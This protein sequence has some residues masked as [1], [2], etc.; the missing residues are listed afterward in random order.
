MS[1][2]EKI[3]KGDFSD[4][5]RD[6]K[7]S[8]YIHPSALARVFATL[9]YA[10]ALQAFQALPDQ[11]QVTTFSYL[12][13]LLQCK[14]IK[15][16]PPE[17]SAFI[18]NELNSDDRMIFFSS[19]KSLE[20]TNF[21]QLLNPK[22]K[23]SVQA[24]LGYPK[25]S[26]ARMMNT[27]VAT[28][29]QEA[30]LAEAI[31]HLRTNHTDSEATNVVFVVDTNNKLIDDIP[32]RRFILNDP[33]KK[34]SDILDGF[35]PSLAITETKDAAVTKFKQL[36]REVLPVINS[37]NVL[38]GVVTIDDI[39]D[40]AEQADTKEIQKIG[41]MEELDYPYVKTSFWELVRKR[42]VWLIILFLGEMLTASAMGYFE[43][44]IAKAVVLAL[45]VPLIISSGG[46]SG[47]QAATLIIRAMA[48]KEIGVKDWWYVMRRE[49]LSGLTLGVVLGAIGFLRI[50]LWQSLKIFDYGAHWFLVGWTIFFSLIG[51][52]M[53]GTLSGSIIP[54]ILK[55]FKL[56]PATSS[57]PFVATLVDVTGL[58]I[59]FSIASVI[60]KGTIL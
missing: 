19:L 16:L 20:Q 7:D 41:G 55:R 47:S 13:V 5:L 51:I 6:R 58:V 44:E 56:D 23:D 28:I 54:M 40:I 50:A 49:V 11:N 60:L 30:T 25:N 18:L 38:L 8:N 26:V 12:D 4:L 59:Y 33:Q 10:N 37:E 53:W 1:I 45:F 35:C 17:K 15:S 22:N 2:I 39:L 9:P 46:N 29:H 43:N 48:L 21:L 14:F 3:I 32:I 52:V 27:N 34:V 42:A 36:D 24:L 57:A 31:L